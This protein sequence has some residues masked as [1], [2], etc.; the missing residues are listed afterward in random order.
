[1]K[2]IFILFVLLGSFFNALA[3]SQYRTKASGNY[4]NAAIWEIKAGFVWIQATS[5]PV[6]EDVSYIQ[7]SSYDTVTVDVNVNLLNSVVNQHADFIVSANAYLI[8]SNN[9]HINAEVVVNNADKST[10]QINSNATIE[11]G[12]TGD[13]IKFVSHLTLSTGCLVGF[14]WSTTT[15]IS[16]PLNI[17]YYNAGSV[18]TNDFISQ[19]GLLYVYNTTFTFNDAG[20][21]VDNF[22]CHANSVINIDATTSFV[23]DYQMANST[24]NLNSSLYYSCNQDIG[25]G[26]IT[27]L[28]VL[29][30]GT[31]AELHFV[32]NNGGI[33]IPSF[34]SLKKLEIN[35]AQGQY[36]QL[37]DDLK[38]TDPQGLILTKGDLITGASNRIILESDAPVYA[39]ALST[40]WG[41]VSIK[42]QTASTATFEYINF[43]IGFNHTS[44]PMRVNLSTNFLGACYLTASV[45]NVVPSGT[46]DNISLGGAMYNRYYTLKVEQPNPNFNS[47]TI[48]AIAN[49]EL[50][51]TNIS[52]TL[53]SVA[54]I[55]FSYDNTANSYAGITSSVSPP[56]I[57]S[58]QLNAAQIA[59]LGSANGSYIGIAY[60]P[61]TAGVYCIGSSASYTAPTGILN[62]YVYQ[63]GNNPYNSVQEA[64]DDL[65]LKGAAGDVIFEIQNN[66][67][68]N[69]DPNTVQISYH[70]TSANKATLRVRSDL[71][72][73]RQFFKTASGQPLFS[74]NGASFVTISGS[75]NHV[76]C[77]NTKG[78]E[79]KNLAGT[80]ASKVISFDN[81]CSNITI[82]DVLIKVPIANTNNCGVYFD[83]T[84]GVNGN[85]DITLKCN[86]FEPI[87][88]I[89]GS[90]N[91][92]QVGTCAT[93]LRNNN[94][95]IDNNEFDA[96]GS[97]VI[98]VHPTSNAS[99]SWTIKDNSFYKN[100]GG[101]SF[102]NFIYFNPNDTVTANISGNYF[103]GSGKLC[104]GAKFDMLSTTPLINLSV[105]KLSTVQ[106]IFSNNHFENMDEDFMV[107]GFTLANFYS[108]GWD[109]NGNNFGSTTAPNDLSSAVNLNF[110]GI[111]VFTTDATNTKALRVRHNSFNNIQFTALPGLGNF[112]GINITSVGTGNVAIDSNTFNNI[113]HSAS[114]FN[115]IFCN[116]D[117]GSNTCNNNMFQSIYAKGY[118][119]GTLIY[120]DGNNYE[121]K[122]NKIGRENINDDIK[123]EQVSVRGIEANSIGGYL[124]CDS[125]EIFQVIHNN[126]NIQS[127]SCYILNL[128][129]TASDYS[130]SFNVIKKIK[131][132]SLWSYPEGDGFYTLCGMNLQTFNNS[133]IIVRDNTI[134]DL[135]VVNSTTTNP[136][137]LC[138]IHSGATGQM[139]NN[140]IS[141][142]VNLGT[143]VANK[144]FTVGICVKGKK[145]TL[146][147][148]VISID[149][150]NNANSINIFGIRKEV[151]LQQFIVLIHNSI[152][153]GGTSS[154]GK[155]FALY[156]NT[157][158][159][160]LNF[161]YDTTYNNIFCNARLGGDNFAA[162]SI[163]AG[164][165]WGNADN[166]L[167]YS[168]DTNKI[169]GFSDGTLFKSFSQWKT[170][171]VGRDINS[172]QRIV[173]FINPANGDLHLNA[174]SSCL[175][176]NA[177]AVGLGIATDI[178][179]EVRNN[180]PDIGAD[181]F[182]Y[183]ANWANATSNSPVC[184]PPNPLIMQVTGN[185]VQPLTF[186]WIGPNSFASTAD[187]PMIN[188]PT[189]ALHE[190]VYTATITDG[191]GCTATSSVSVLV[192]DAQTWYLDEDG[193]NYYNG[194][195]VSACSSPGVFYTTINLGIDCDDADVNANPG[196]TEVCGN[197]ID[198]NCDG[199][200]DE[201]CNSVH[202]LAGKVFMQG[203]YLGGGLMNSVLLNQNE[204][205]N[206]LVCDSIQVELHDISNITNII[207]NSTSVVETNG[208][209]TIIGIPNSLLN[210]S[211][212]LAI[213]HRNSVETWSSM[214]IL[215]TSYTYYN[216]TTN[217]SK[218]YG[219]NQKEL[220]TGV[221]ALYTGDI[222]QDGYIDGFDYPMFDDDTQNNVSGVYVNTDLN[223]D[224]YVD[225]FDY[226]LFDENSQNNITSSTP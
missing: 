48:Y 198:D 195:S 53:S 140:T 78:I 108:A 200:V 66:Y 137:S 5:A 120:V 203:Y 154:G 33:T 3:V 106:A 115:P 133:S 210:N 161:H 45:Q 166:N 64:F 61:L 189:H 109:I 131:T 132:K 56:F 91:A 77:G 21:S 54:K 65:A 8:F 2:K 28:C 163:Y 68:F 74:F 37:S 123:L 134:S 20:I 145:D 167:F 16:E 30:A 29:N 88:N 221:F 170:L 142:L 31:N 93:T 121:V 209:F 114:T 6:S 124:H 11:V 63:N 13:L 9:H 73:P 59:D 143:S 86:R 119:T 98:D 172:L 52:P 32:S 220:E 71:T 126:Q 185:G 182:N 26:V 216:F 107:N 117:Y 157:N 99:G 105:S 75:M 211:Y 191:N 111:K 155:S 218:A 40:V 46:A 194:N 81:D 130:A 136:I 224:G 197:S 147:N 101:S 162:G 171:L 23:T 174:I 60:Q 82:S 158:G 168:A 69:Q 128:S 38:I 214:P 176:N 27:Y 223:G 83:C 85:S 100:L 1:M 144:S 12:Q 110:S 139:F 97:Y 47:N 43:P 10:Y 165:N 87:T 76:L 102:S 125:N 42:V 39:S 49:I 95:V 57:T 58:L 225:G 193:D 51:P 80:S 204:S 67:N 151:D 118:G 92:I 90:T 35:I 127:L 18:S 201:G 44:M 153:I 156:K 4:S 24:F 196:A 17:K 135:Q 183:N 160:P 222:N 192:N 103:G 150:G 70:G 199:N 159:G 208:E 213:R 62:N 141:K 164:N 180:P 175:L 148:N 184:G 129:C 173:A 146:F 50:T 215:I 55:G 113:T 96:C 207:Y 206:P 187:D 72:N 116:A 178:D 89:S 25:I 104:S 79:F 14:A 36:L 217:A 202:I 15:A 226:P 188:S 22:S 138:A 84:N 190:G 181:E 212:Y 169:G 205:I 152:Y 179:G 122:R 94:V 177:G 41:N 19:Y 34:A 219:G 186:N 149:N 112:Y 7:I